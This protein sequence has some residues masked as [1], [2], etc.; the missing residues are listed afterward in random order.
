MHARLPLPQLSKG[1]VH[2]REQDNKCTGHTVYV[3]PTFRLLRRVQHW[4]KNLAKGRLRITVLKNSAHFSFFKVEN[5]SD[6]KINSLIYN[7]L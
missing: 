3:V 4:I 5:E 1:G 6:F 2:K 7:I